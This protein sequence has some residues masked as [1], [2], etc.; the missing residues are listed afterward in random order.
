MTSQDSLPDY[1]DIDELSEPLEKKYK[2]NLL[3]CK[4]CKHIQI[5]HTIYP[6]IM[7][8]NYLWETAVSKTNIILIVYELHINTI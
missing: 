5:G 7:F 6:D 1:E 2:L 3:L 4:N 8:K